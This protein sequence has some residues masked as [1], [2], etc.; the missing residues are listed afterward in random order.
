MNWEKTWPN[1]SNADLLDAYCTL[2]DE[3]RT[4]K[5]VRSGN[6]P[7]ADLAEALFSGA[8][9]LT[10]VGRSNAGYDAL[11]AAGLRYQIKAR[12]RTGH[13]RSAQL[14][15]IRN[16]ATQPFDLLAA[17]IYHADLSVEYAA[18]IP[19]QVVKEMSSFS[20]HTNAHIFHFRLSVLEDARVVDVTDELR[21]YTEA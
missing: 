7:V 8:F 10:L 19:L 14:G 12:R 2:M 20:P 13:N 21:A 11:D 3:L 18:L 6:N 5:V 15:H 4:R 9:G 17:V 16:L 1:Y